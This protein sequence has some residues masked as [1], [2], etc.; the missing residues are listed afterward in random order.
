[1]SDL[2]VRYLHIQKLK[3][4]SKEAK[5]RNIAASWTAS[6]LRGLFASTVLPVRSRYKSSVSQNW[7]AAM[8][9]QS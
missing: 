1:M 9:S 3:A 2:E 6:Y 7:I 8:T 4:K 5:S